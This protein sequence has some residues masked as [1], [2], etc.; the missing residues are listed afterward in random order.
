MVV[1]RIST[2]KYANDLSGVGA[3]L[4]GG[5]WN[6]KGLN[7]VYTAGSISLACLEY[8]VHNIHLMS[9]KV[10]CLSKIQVSDTAPIRHIN[11]KELPTDWDEKSYLPLSTQNI[12]SQFF[13]AESEYVL[14]VPS[15]IIPDEFNYLLNP[16]HRLHK[17]TKIV[18]QIFPF[19]MDERLFG[20]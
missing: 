16:M 12:G 17:E 14:K 3:G 15:I 18:E 4:Y 2:N 5:I 13:E 20:V 1:Y 8:M 10:I 11:R 6:P 7:L 19:N 9:S